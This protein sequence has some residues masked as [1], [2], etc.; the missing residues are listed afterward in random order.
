MKDIRIYAQPNCASQEID[1]FILVGNAY[2][3]DVL[4]DD[5]Q[6]EAARRA[7]S[8]SIPEG[9]AQMLMD[10]LWRCG[11]RPTEARSGAGTVEAMQRHLD[12]L[13]EIAF[14]QLKMKPRA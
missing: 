11:L 10:Q 3:V 6:D 5:K 7:P 2:V 4:M 1:L 13:R 12:D 9:T 14:H 8:L